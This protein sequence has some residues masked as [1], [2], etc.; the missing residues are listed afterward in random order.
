MVKTSATQRTSSQVA[1]DR[2]WWRPKPGVGPLDAWSLVHTASGLGL[3]LLPFPWWVALILL[4]GY[5]VFEAGLRRVRH[6]AG[7]F[8]HESRLNIAADVVIGMAGWAGSHFALY[9]S[10]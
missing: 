7:I 5:E 4:A 6:G 10:F 2:P 3:G 8:E 9:R 1:P